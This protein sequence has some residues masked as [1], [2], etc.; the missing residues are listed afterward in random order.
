[1]SS[2]NVKFKEGSVITPCPKCGNKLEFKARSERVC[3]DGCEIWIECKC[4]YNPFGSGDALED[5][6]GGCDDDNVMW[7]IG[8][9]NELLNTQQHPSPVTDQKKQ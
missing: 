3:E 5:V 2:R 8:Q 9:W 4:G 7:A 6:W 1:M